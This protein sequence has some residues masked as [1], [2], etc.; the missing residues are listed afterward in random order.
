MSVAETDPA[1]ASE[2]APPPAPTG[3]V[4]RIQS[5]EIE[6]L[7][8][9]K[10][11]KLEGLAPLTVLTGPNGSGKSTVLDALDIGGG[12]HAGV[13]TA[14]VATR[15][16]GRTAGPRWLTVGGKGD[17][18]SLVVHPSEGKPIYRELYLSS[19]PNGLPLLRIVRFA[20]DP[21]RYA[22]PG[23]LFTDSIRFEEDG[24]PDVSGLGYGSSKDPVLPSAKGVWYID[25][26][27][28][29][30]AGYYYS[31]AVR[32]GKKRAAIEFAR[33]LDNTVVG[34]DTLTER[35]GASN[36]YIDRGAFAL[37]LG[38]EADG[39]RSALLTAM[40]L[41]LSGEH[42]VLLEE[43]EAHLHPAAMVLVA[44]AIVNA[45]RS[46]TQV[47]LT[48]HSIEFL[49]C[50]LD[51]SENDG[52]DFFALFRVHLRDGEL[53]SARH[54]GPEVRFVRDEVSKDLR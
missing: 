2:A 19:Q 40:K 11:G 16:G 5:V 7:R 46:G 22:Q 32:R 26:Q 12:Q 34:L 35:G 50:L 14:A 39:F 23:E 43:P 27:D 42:V 31:E 1:A 29:E 21:R 49:D 36:L 33:Q 54:A 37:P 47:V 51:E 4:A 25:P 13:A 24:R 20:N 53:V 6:N 3:A 52:D 48:T 17:T 9:I 30:G 38:A 8:G 45:V 44:K 10:S 41:V 28:K 18:V 15:R